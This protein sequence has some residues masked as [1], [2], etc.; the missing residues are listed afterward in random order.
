MRRPP[1]RSTL[2]PYTT[3]F[4]S[5][6]HEVKV[7]TGIRSAGRTQITSGLAGGETVVTQG[8][9]GL[10]DGTKVALPAPGGGQ[11]KA[12]PTEGSCQLPAGGQAEACPTEGSC[13][14]PGGGQ[15]EA[16]PTEGLCQ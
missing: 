4:R 9:Y 6:A 2:F 13:Q 11:A 14:L 7:T 1:P 8:N 15:G 5:V 10:P 3:L 16:C 12:C